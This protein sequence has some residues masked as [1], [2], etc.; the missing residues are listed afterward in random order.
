MQGAPLL[1]LLFSL[2]HL[3]SLHLFYLVLGDAVVAW[4]HSDVLSEPHAPGSGAGSPQGVAQSMQV[5]LRVLSLS[6]SLSQFR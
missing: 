5:G 3:T 1:E 6:L 2:A 4:A